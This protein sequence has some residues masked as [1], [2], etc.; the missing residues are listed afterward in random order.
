ME[1]MW[2]LE[3]E[4][5]LKGFRTNKLSAVSLVQFCGRPLRDANVCIQ[6][7]FHSSRILRIFYF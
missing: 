5:V 4:V 3:H 6:P 7:Q 1:E 2:Y